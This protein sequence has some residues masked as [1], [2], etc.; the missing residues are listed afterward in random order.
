MSIESVEYVQLRRS[1]E[2]D[3]DTFWYRSDP[4]RKRMVQ[5]VADGLF[6]SWFPHYPAK[7]PQGDD[8]KNWISIAYQDA[9]VAIKALLRGAWIDDP[10]MD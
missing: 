4:Q 2:T 7:G 8:L 3:W 1:S 10:T 6:L 5:Q 9:E